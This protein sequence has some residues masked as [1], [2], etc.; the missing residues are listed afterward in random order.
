MISSEMISSNKD[1]KGM[2]FRNEWTRKTRRRRRRKRKG[3]QRKERETSTPVTVAFRSNCW[4]VN[5][6]LVKA[7]VIDYSLKNGAETDME[8]LT[9][10]N[11]PKSNVTSK[12]RSRHRVLDLNGKHKI[13]T[14]K[15]KPVAK[16]VW[17]LNFK[18]KVVLDHWGL[19]HVGT[20]PST[21][22]HVTTALRLS[23]TFST[24]QS[25]SK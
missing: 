6:W 17:V 8:N 11:T 24:I 1:S 3:R 22:D 16:A 7:W 13:K 5:R 15:P 19:S 20:V 2:I 9:E 4:Y 12:L 23:G 25:Q 10:V 18:F 21:A 14:S